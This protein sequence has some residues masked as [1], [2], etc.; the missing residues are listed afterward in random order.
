MRVGDDKSQVMDGIVRQMRDYNIS[1]TELALAME[2][3]QVMGPGFERFIFAAIR[4][5]TGGSAPGE[6]FKKLYPTLA[7]IIIFAVA[8]ALTSKFWAGMNAFSHIMITLGAGLLLHV[9]ALVALKKKR[10]P[11]VI[12]PLLLIAAMLQPF[13]W[14]VMVRE[15]FPD[16]VSPYVLSVL[17]M[18]VM[19]VQHGMAWRKHKLALLLFLTLLFAYSF[20]VTWL[21]LLGASERI[22]L[23]GIGLAVMGT[24]QALRHTPYASL[25]SIGYVLGAAAFALGGFEILRA[26]PVE[27]MYLALP[28]AMAYASVRVRSVAMLLVGTIAMLSYIAYF[29]SQHLAHFAGWALTLVALGIIFYGIG[30]A[31]LAIKRRYIDIPVT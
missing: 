16:M 20:V 15:L 7:A 22:I 29:A 27:L 5:M 14:F 26:S 18:A 31:A 21:S 25:S 19:A 12:S 13:G 28:C 11:R 8:C 2:R 9:F 4:K 6:F 3:A 23:V 10:L 30:V 24:A 17:I 1:M